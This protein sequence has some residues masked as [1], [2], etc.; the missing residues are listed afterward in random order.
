MKKLT[1]IACAVGVVAGGLATVAQAGQ[2]QASATSYAREAINTDTLP[3]AMPVV[4]YKLFGSVD[5]SAQLQR[6]SI[7]VDISAG[8]YGA[9][10]APGSVFISDQTVLTIGGFTADTTSISGTKL[11]I[12]FVIPQ[13]P[14]LTFSNPIIR[15]NAVS[16]VGASASMSDTQVAGAVTVGAGTIKGLGALNAFDATT[17]ATA[18]AIGSKSISATVTHKD[19]TGAIDDSNRPSSANTANILNFP[20]THLGVTTANVLAGALDIANS[21][22]SFVAGNGGS[23]SGAAG[24]GAI[25]V[26]LAN[27]GRVVL[28]SKTSAAFAALPLAASVQAVLGVGSDSSGNAVNYGLPTAP[29]A[30]A[31]A[32]TVNAGVMEIGNVAVDVV[33]DQ[34]YVVGGSLAL[35]TTA[36]C[37]ALLGAVPITASNSAAG[38]KITMTTPGAATA[39]QQYFVC[40]T[41]PTGAAALQ[42][43]S[44]GFKAIARW[45]KATG[46]LG[47]QTN[48]S[49][50]A[51]LFSLGGAVK[52]DVRNYVP[53]ARSAV[54]NW[55]SVLRLINNSEVNDVRVFA[56]TIDKDGKFGNS[57]LIKTLKPRAAVY[58]LNSEVDAILKGTT[59][60]ASSAVAA[61][62]STNLVGN[63]TD[64]DNTR[65]RITGEGSNTLRVQNYL[66]GPQGQFLEASGAQG[67]DFGPITDRAADAGALL[68]QDAPLG[69]NGR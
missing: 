11:T 48:T 28:V 25:S 38:S 37:A 33:A 32:G 47:E 23:L 44:S 35:S 46:D 69:L 16:G 50:D 17:N 24:T 66:V 63:A 15:V 6:F 39:V 9:A 54:T 53:A 42:I 12:N 55:T 7:E 67:V 29:V 43:P 41:V 21:N 31:A 5:A 57:A 22:K 3:L 59:A 65:L 10:P 20:T 40:Y 1:L 34:G 51:P 68:D 56:Q 27:L 4:G 45:A 30:N 8:S 60:T 36:N 19:A 2:I 61:A 52:I 58:M 62:V 14:G 13:T 18:C 64:V 26:S 49:C